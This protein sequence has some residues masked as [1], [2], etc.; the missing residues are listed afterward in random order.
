MKTTN[1]KNITNMKVDIKDLYERLISL[2]AKF[3]LSYSKSLETSAKFEGYVFWLFFLSGV[4]I[5]LTIISII[6]HIFIFGS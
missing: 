2:E 5:A 1:E 6:V 3:D 4:N